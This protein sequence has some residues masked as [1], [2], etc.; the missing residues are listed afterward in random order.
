ML[1]CMLPEQDFGDE[2]DECGQLLCDQAEQ[3]QSS[4]RVE[5]QVVER[6]MNRRMIISRDSKERGRAEFLLRGAC[7][8]QILEVA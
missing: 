6:I 1:L 8:W 4:R 2:A 5:A 3:P 7:Y